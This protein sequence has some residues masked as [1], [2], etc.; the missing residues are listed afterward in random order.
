MRLTSYTDY[1]L[2]V[3]IFVAARPDQR[4]T[5]AEIAPHSS[6][7]ESSAMTDTTPN[8]NATPKT[9]KRRGI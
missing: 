2:R 9:G 6:R 7:G 3:L 4:A 8:T 5:I 1:C